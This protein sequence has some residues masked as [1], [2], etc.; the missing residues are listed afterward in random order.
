MFLRNDSPL[1]IFHRKLEVG[2]QSV[3]RTRV[4]DKTFENHW[5]TG[6]KKIYGKR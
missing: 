6:S 3:E 5:Y 1:M 4:E 2:F